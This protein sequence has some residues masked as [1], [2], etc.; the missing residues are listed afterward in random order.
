MTIIRFS[1]LFIFVLLNVLIIASCHP[2]ENQKII[3][4]Q[5]AEINVIDFTGK[6]V[7][8]PVIG[9]DETLVCVVVPKS[10][11]NEAL[12]DQKNEEKGHSVDHFDNTKSHEINLANIDSPVSHSSVQPNVIVPSDD[13]KT[14]LERPKPAEVQA[15]LN[16]SDSKDH[17]KQSLDP[18]TL[19]H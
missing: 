3:G 11:V 19:E 18:K 7:A 10:D 5:E 6:F 1:F 15:K 9:S 12:K 14:V 2:A 17:L 8:N 16:E 4:S 13:Q